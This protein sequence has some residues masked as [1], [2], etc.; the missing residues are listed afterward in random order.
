[1]FHVA[2]I[3]ALFTA[4]KIFLQCMSEANLLRIRQHMIK[5]RDCETV[6]VTKVLRYLEDVVSSVGES[7]L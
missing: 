3:F 2:V 5:K 6:T 7:Y 1:M 4:L